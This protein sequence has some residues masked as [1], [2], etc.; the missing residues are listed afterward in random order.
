ME[1]AVEKCLWELLDAES[2]AC[3]LTDLQS[4]KISID[5]SK[6]SPIGKAGIEERGDVMMPQRPTHA[7]LMAMKSRLEKE[8][9]AIVCT[10]CKAKSIRQVSAIDEN[11]S[12]TK[13]GSIMLAILRRAD[14]G[15]IKL[16]DKKKPTTEDKKIIKR[17]MKSA[18]LVKSH[19]EK[20]LLALAARGIGPDKAA[21]ILAQQYEDEDEFLAEI[22]NAEVTYARTRRFW[23]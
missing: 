7:I 1:E 14:M 12:C 6:L 2:A 18:N 17:I 4:G 15:N 22:L 5:V 13:C 23:D 21:K 8:R 3:V 20:A 19:G 11:P 10:H 16:M 9:V